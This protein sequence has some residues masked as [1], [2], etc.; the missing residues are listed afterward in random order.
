[1]VNT[2]AFPVPLTVNVTVNVLELLIT[3]EAEEMSCPAV[4]VMLGTAVVLNSKP[5]GALRTSVRPVPLPLSA[6]FPSSMMIGPTV[7]KPGDG[8]FARLDDAR[9]NHHRRGK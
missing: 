4:K 3:T 8:A 7:L 1:M 5:A 6:L 2:S 9:T